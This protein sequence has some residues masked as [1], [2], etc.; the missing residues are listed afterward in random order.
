LVVFGYYAL[1]PGALGYSIV[2]SAKYGALNVGTLLVALIAGVAV[3][4]IAASR[5]RRRQLT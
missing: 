2:W 3:W 5:R 1:L 4:V